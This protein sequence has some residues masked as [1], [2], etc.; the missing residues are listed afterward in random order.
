VTLQITK[1][2]SAGIYLNCECLLQV[3]YMEL[4]A[5]IW[6]LTT[7]GSRSLSHVT[8]I[9]NGQVELQ[10]LYVDLTWNGPQVISFPMYHFPASFN[11]F[12]FHKNTI[13][14]FN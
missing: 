12:C 13:L 2:F 4:K 14:E 1:S 8:E 9:Q 7:A 3:N 5:E 11:I 10:F 6:L